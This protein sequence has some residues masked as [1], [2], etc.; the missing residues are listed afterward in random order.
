MSHSAEMVQASPEQVRS[1]E[2]RESAFIYLFL[3][4]KLGKSQKTGKISKVKKAQ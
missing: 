3:I 4:S 1:P 2:G